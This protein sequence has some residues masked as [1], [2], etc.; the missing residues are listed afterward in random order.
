MSKLASKGQ[1]SADFLVVAV[2][3]LL[4]ILALITVYMEKL[5]GTNSV[6][7]RLAGQRLADHVARNVNAVAFGCN[8]S[9]A[10]ITLPESLKGGTEYNI[11][12]LSRGRRVEIFWY[13]RD[14]FYSATS[15]IVTS[16]VTDVNKS[17]FI[18]SGNKEVNITNVNG[19]VLVGAD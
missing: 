3:A 8:G 18:G 6:T 4:L 14:T 9:K 16:N 17:F 13:S 11:S 10:T 19:R 7:N 5:Y 2:F 15:S 1:S 12:I